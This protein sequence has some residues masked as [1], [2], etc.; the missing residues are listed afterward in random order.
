MKARVQAC[1]AQ[2]KKKLYAEEACTHDALIHE[3]WKPHKTLI[4]HSH[5]RCQKFA[6]EA[7]EVRKP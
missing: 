4:Q 5:I 3:S 1:M 2:M 7:D 6:T